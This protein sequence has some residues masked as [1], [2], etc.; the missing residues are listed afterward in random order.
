[1]AASDAAT[2][3][4]STRINALDLMRGYLI[5]VII[6]VHL[7]YYPSLLGAFDGRGQLWVSEAE[8]FFF[9]SGLLIG[10][11]RRRDIERSGFMTA[12]VKVLKRGLRLYLTGAVL[13]I[14]YLCWGRWMIGISPD[15]VKGGLDTSSSV[16]PLAWSIITLKYSYGWSDFLIFYAGFLF[17][18]PIVLWLLL[19]RLWWVVLSATLGLWLWRWNGGYGPYNSFL[20]WQVYFFLGTLIGYYWH[21]LGAALARLPGG[22]QR[23]V[24]LGAVIVTVMMAVGGLLA[25]FGPQN[26][27]S[28]LFAWIHAVNASTFYNRMLTD[29]RDG[30]LRPIVLLVTFA[31]AF[32]LVRRYEHKIMHYAGW[33]LLP[34]GRNSLYVY[35][36]GGLALFTIPFFAH[37][38]SFWLNSALEVGTITVIWLAVK[39]KVLFKIIPR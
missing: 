12:A 25:V 21:T 35:I 11:I 3:A 24:K 15:S 16:L 34:F 14:L 33:L 7:A 28:S 6:S 31:G 17:V 29:G 20:Q 30:L 32:T 19:K 4:P 2:S 10:I 38:G 13:T 37:A 9:I 26:S 5:M 36:L 22:W 18:T 23:A 39:H 8:G 27:S 1:M